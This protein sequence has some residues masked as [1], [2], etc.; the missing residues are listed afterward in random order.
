[1]Q[2]VTM[3]V[4]LGLDRLLIRRVARDRSRLRELMDVLSL[5]VVVGI[6]VALLGILA[7][8]LLGYDSTTVATVALLAPGL[9]ADSFA[10]SVFGIFTAYEESSLLSLSLVVQRVLA[11]TLGLGALALGFG[12]IAVAATFTAGTATGLLMA[13]A[14]AARR[15]G[16]PPVRI[17]RRR[18]RLLTGQSLPFAV[19]DIFGVLLAKLD[20]VILA[21]LASEA[22]V[23][24]YGGAYRLL[25]ATFFLSS[26]VNG[27]FAAM[28]SYLGPTTDPP[29][30]AVAQRS[31]KL[32]LFLLVPCAVT[33]GVLAEPVTVLF[34]G[35]GF[36]GAAE[37]L[38]LLAP[39]VVLMGLVYLATSM[40]VSRGNPRRIVK[41]TAGAVAVNVTLNVL[42]IPILG[43]RGAAGAMVLTEI[44]LTAVLLPIAVRRVGH[45]RW[46]S[47]L[48]GPLLAGLA[49]GVAMLP[50]ADSLLPA[51]PIGAAVYAL[52]LLAVER[53][54]DPSDVRFVS[55]LLRKRL[56]PGP[57]R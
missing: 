11:A 31:I 51:L 1:M 19:Q 38:R 26:S 23:G 4:G 16:L 12:V 35:E 21:L 20:V 55:G 18:W 42:L 44:A 40:I 34:L 29:V 49:M 13:I 8:V 53:A 39:A 5:K 22:A 24:R 56:A 32:L 9:L 45:L 37:P 15:I 6:P 7:I 30:A 33:L 2:I 10:R 52:V 57:T 14:L 25:E 54:V 36:R 41:L 46:A 47:M 3:P 43:D 50:L 48:A 27:A 28:Y 17:S